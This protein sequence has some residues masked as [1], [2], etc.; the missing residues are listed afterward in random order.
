LL[1]TVILPVVRFSA[2]GRGELYLRF[3]RQ[4]PT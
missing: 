4:P 3:V 2:G 1:A